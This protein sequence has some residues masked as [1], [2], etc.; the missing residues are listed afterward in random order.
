MTGPHKP[1]N[2]SLVKV[3]TVNNDIL[4][5][6]EKLIKP[7]SKVA[8]A[9]SGGAD[10][11]LLL[12]LCS[13][14]LPGNV[15]ALTASTVFQTEEEIE[16]C[17]RS[18]RKL[19]I[20]HRVI[21]VEILSDPAI[22]S[23][24]P[25]RCY[26]CKKRL[27]GAML[28]AAEEEGCRV[29]LD[30]TNKDDTA[31][32][33]PGLRALEELGIISPFLVAGAGKKWIRETSKKCQVSTW[34]RPSNACL[35]SRIPYDTPID[36]EL[37]KKIENGEKI[38]ENHGFAKRRLRVYNDIACIEIEQARI[39]SMFTDGRYISILAG[40]KKLG[41]RTIA[42]DLE[43]FVSGKLNRGLKAREQVKG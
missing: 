25:D 27:F 4:D 15:V 8:V 20:D 24:P 33:R 34:D 3:E 7:F 38:L 5:K 14:F 11:S 23:N 29:V 35:A 17:K 36:R 10:S 6:L 43:G 22:A 21:P 18:T 1:G 41:F 19:G 30:G 16:L 9:F 32:Y 26:H 13:K 42:L 39:E 12:F 28:K 31:D 40:L 2:T 37:L